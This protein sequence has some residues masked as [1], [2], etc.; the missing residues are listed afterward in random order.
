M[1]P[2]RMPRDGEGIDWSYA[3]AGEGLPKIDGKLPEARKRQVRI[4][5]QVSEGHGSV[6]ILIWDF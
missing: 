6:D 4:P 3:A 1:H 2:E 5:W